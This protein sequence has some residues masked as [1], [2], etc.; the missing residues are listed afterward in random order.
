[1]SEGTNDASTPWRDV[2]EIQLLHEMRRGVNAAFTEFFR[3]FSPLLVTMARRRQVPTHDRTELVT[4]YLEDAVIAM[5]T[6][7]RPAP[8]SFAP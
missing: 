5:V 1:M 7:T 8:T 6:R 4:E 2:D 3:R